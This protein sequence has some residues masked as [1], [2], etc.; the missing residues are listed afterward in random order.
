MEQNCYIIMTD[1]DKL[2]RLILKLTQFVFRG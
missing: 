2:I 1:E